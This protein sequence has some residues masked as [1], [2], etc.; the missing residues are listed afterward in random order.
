MRDAMLERQNWNHL[1]LTFDPKIENN[2]WKLFKLAFLHWS[3]LRKRLIYHYGDIKYIQCWEIHHSGLP[4]CHVALQNEKLFHTLSTDHIRNFHNYVREHAVA[5]S[6][7]EN[8]TIEALR[9]KV[10]FA[11]YL[12]KLA[13]ELTGNPSKAYQIP[14][15][16]PPNFRRIRASWRLLP[17]VIKNKDYTGELCGIDDQGEICPLAELD[18]EGKKK[19]AVM[20][21]GPRPGSLPRSE[22]TQ[23]LSLFPSALSILE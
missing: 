3:V 4:H 22:Q 5:S 16:A 17:P 18:S 21:D 9:D 19:R 1:C 10:A 12:N 6:F 7:G 15:N 13:A 11:G 14:V 20:D 2:P 8:G 23:A